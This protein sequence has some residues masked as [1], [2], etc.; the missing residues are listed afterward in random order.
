MCQRHLFLTP[1]RPLCPPT[2]TAMILPHGAQKQG[3]Q[4]EFFFVNQYVYVCLGGDWHFDRAM[5][6]AGKC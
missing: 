2:N 6:F 1:A 5:T 3:P 4:N